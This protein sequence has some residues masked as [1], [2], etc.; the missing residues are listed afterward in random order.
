MSYITLVV[1]SPGYLSSTEIFEVG[2]YNSWTEMASLP[3]AS[4]GARAA[5]LDNRIYLAGGREGE[6]YDW[7]RHDE[8]LMWEE[9]AVGGGNWSLVGR[10][11]TS[12]Y[13]HAVST[14]SRESHQDLFAY[15]Q[16]YSSTHD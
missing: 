9:E 2:S 15:C 4:W 16:D 5:T 3:V 6:I 8:I 14:I 11:T 10:M 1:F 7:V 12:R 13:D